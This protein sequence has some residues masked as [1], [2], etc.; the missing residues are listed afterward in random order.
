MNYNQNLLIH[1]I[2][3]SQERQAKS[4]K[5]IQLKLNEMNQEKSFTTAIWERS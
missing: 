3:E 4:L 1:A 5:N 2:Q